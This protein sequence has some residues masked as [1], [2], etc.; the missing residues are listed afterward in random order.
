MLFVSYTL[1][2]RNVEIIIKVLMLLP[3][4]DA[5]DSLFAKHVSNTCVL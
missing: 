2:F 5:L 1:E 4:F 3:F